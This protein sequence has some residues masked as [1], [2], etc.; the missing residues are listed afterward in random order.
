MFSNDYGLALDPYAKI[1]DLSVGERQ[2]EPNVNF[3]VAALGPRA[4]R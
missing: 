4:E 1:D 2:R 3:S